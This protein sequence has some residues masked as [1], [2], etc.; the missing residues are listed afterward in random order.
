MMF[1]Y[2]VGNNH[3]ISKPW[4][5][6]Q[7]IIIIQI[8]AGLPRGRLSGRVEK[9]NTSKV[10]NQESRDAF[11]MNLLK[12]ESFSYASLMPYCYCLRGTGREYMF[13]FF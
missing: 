8:S 12:F 10:K 11:M 5:G 2:R 1:N 3:S 4:T 13:F 7:Q 6:R 9:K